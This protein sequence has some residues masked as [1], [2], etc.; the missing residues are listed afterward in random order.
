MITLEDLLMRGMKPEKFMPSK[1]D[2][3]PRQIAKFEQ[4]MMHKR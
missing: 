1:T 4:D 2:E 3:F